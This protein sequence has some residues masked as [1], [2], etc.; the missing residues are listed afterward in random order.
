MV[1]I[2]AGI[3]LA[4]FLGFSLRYTWWWLPRKGMLAL[5]YHN[6]EA[7]PNPDTKEAAFYIDPQTF[8]KQIDALKAAGFTL[9]NFEDLT[10]IYQGKQAAPKKPALITL[11]D[12]YLNNYTNAFPILKE[13]NAK[14]SIFLTYNDIGVK[15]KF[16]NWAQVLEMQASGLVSFGSHTLTHSRLRSLSTAS[17]LAE[18]TESKTMLEEKLSRPVTAF[19]YPFGAGG[20]DKRIRP[21]VFDAGYLFDFSTAKGINKWPWNNKK[22]ILRAFPRGGETSLDFKLQ[23]TRGRSKL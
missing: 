6:I 16:L 7:A 11:D 23:M 10:A 12:G 9:I 20:F 22:T 15:E 2:I 4:A 14:A 17:A 5:M 18:L 8:A 13:K 1:Y 21:L 3:F 19:A